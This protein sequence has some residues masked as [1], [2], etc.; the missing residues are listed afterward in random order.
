M[1][2]T[3]DEAQ[4]TQ[5]WHGSTAGERTA[6]RRRQLLDAGFRLLG[7]EG[8]A[9]VTVR[10]VTRTSGVSPKYFYDSFPDRETLLIAVWD[11]QYAELR[12]V[13]DA[14]VNNAPGDFSSRMRAALLATADWLVEVPARGRAM[15]RETMADDLLRRHARKR[16]PELVVETAVLSD[17]GGVLLG[18]LPPERLS[19]SVTALS[20]AIVNLFLEWTGGGLQISRE[21]LVDEVLV[22]TGAVLG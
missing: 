12:V 22:F 4:D 5:R 10:G 6:E 21:Q 19:T 8:A 2:R 13:V 17:D 9:A 1:S 20:G 15:L 14:A 3:S 7:G 16:L 11:E 18:S